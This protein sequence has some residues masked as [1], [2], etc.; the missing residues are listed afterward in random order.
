[1]SFRSALVSAEHNPFY[2]ASFRDGALVSEPP[3]G[4]Q[5]HRLTRLCEVLLTAGSCGLR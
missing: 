1:M 3:M 4:F 5:A 2:P